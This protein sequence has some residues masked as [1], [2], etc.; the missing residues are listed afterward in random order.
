MASYEALGAGGCVIGERLFSNFGYV[1][2]SGGN[3]TAVADTAVFLTP[4]DGA[5][6][7]GIMFLEQQL[8][9]APAIP[10]CPH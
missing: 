6:G 5:Q 7:P 1:S 9:R 2:T 4:V 8:E 10:F 3:G